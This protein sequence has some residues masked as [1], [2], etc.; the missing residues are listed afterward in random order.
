MTKL[1]AACYHCGLEVPPH[2]DYYVSIDDK[3]Q[4]MC[5]PGCAA[6]AQ[7]IVDNHLTDY[8][9][10]RTAAATTGRNLIPAELQQL[11]IFDNPKLQ[12]QFVTTT[13]IADIKEASLIL[14]G[15]V[16]AACVWLNERHVG[17]LPGVAEFRVNYT[18]HRATVKWNETQIKLSDILQ[19]ITAIGYQA[20]PVDAQRLEL[21]QQR[22]RNRAMRRLAVAGLGAMQVMMLSVA[23]YA[24]AYYGI[25]AT[26]A[27]FFRWVSLLIAT[28]VVLYAALPF[29]QS[30]WRDLRLRR[31]GMDVPVALSIIAAF[32]ASAY[33]TVL[34]S[35]DVYFDSITMFIFFL[36]TGRYLEMQA[37]HRAGETAEALVKLIPAMATRLTANGL[38]QVIPVSELVPGDVVR[39][40]PG[41]TIPADGKVRAGSSSVDE[42]LLTGESLPIRKL[43]EQLVIGGSVN[44]ESPLEILIDKVGADTVLAAIQRLLDRA[45]TEK[46]DIARLADKVASYF[47]AALFIVAVAIGALWW[48]SGALHA[49]WIVIA[50]LVVTC[51]CALSLATPVALVAATGRLM[52]AGVLTT[53]GHALETLARVTHVVFDKTGTLTYGRLRVEAVEIH[54]SL[55]REKILQIAAALERHSEH[56]LAQALVQFAPDASLQATD[57]IATPGAGMEG[58][59]AMVRYRIGRP[60]FAVPAGK[61]VAL[62]TQRQQTAIVLADTA[63]VHAVFYLQDELRSDAT[64]T[65]RTLQN[66]G[67]QVMLLSGDRQAVVA[68]VA[69]QLGVHA[70]R[71][72]V[73]PQDKL[74]QV[75]QLQASGAVI[76]MLGD[77]VNDAPVLAAA[78]VSIA[79][80]SGTQLAQASSDMVLLSERLLP[81]VFALRMAR[82]THQVIRQNLAWAILYNLI[83]LPLA[84]LGWV[85]P[86][87]AGIGMSASSL[88]VVL[89]SL[90]LR[91][92]TEDIPPQ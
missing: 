31:L 7:A 86:W 66:M 13:A 47:V 92:L 87:M 14:E 89:N 41:E 6:V 52:Q 40:K 11:E 64:Q 26:L 19:A 29:Y 69:Q 38:E 75:Q 63:T 60:E 35:Q 16:C 79:M 88:L 36:L 54:S 77:G 44:I 65:V 25:D 84:A 61:Q 10:Y 46:P 80:G 76:A 42:S 57:C 2:S 90:R 15:I 33:A 24:G 12:Q 56:P 1:S 83:A 5:C 18:T 32:A 27:L 30:A 20:H 43:H 45:Q 49:F 4:A 81:V 34:Q 28:P 73:L 68:Q 58:S 39:V 78:Q 8:Y 22:E 70:W 17:S 51:P 9:R 74:Q 48:A 71:G 85:T 62:D 55:A 53:R 3:P 37:R 50:V 72:E 91:R 23:L 67:V 82:F 21:I 59:I